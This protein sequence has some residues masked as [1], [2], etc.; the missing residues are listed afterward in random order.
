MCIMGAA[1]VFSDQRYMS[2]EHKS[3]C[4]GDLNHHFKGRTMVH[5]AVRT[6]AFY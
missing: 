6:E 5:K 1:G 4:K 3:S 2:L